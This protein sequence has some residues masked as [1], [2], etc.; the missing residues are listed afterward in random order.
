MTELSSSG[1]VAWFFIGFL[2]GIAGI[3]LAYATNIDKFP[4]VRGDA[5]KFSAFGFGTTFLISMLIV[6]AYIVLLISLINNA[7][8]IGW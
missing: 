6:G 5:I 2:A 3:I 1:K 8:H 4:K 7:P